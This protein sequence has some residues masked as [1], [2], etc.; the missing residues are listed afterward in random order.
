MYR[1]L[2]E[3][4]EGFTKNMRPAFEDK[5]G[6]FLLVGATQF[7]CFFAPFVAIFLCPRATRPLVLAEI[8]LIYA[9]R[10]LLTAR[11][12]TSWLGCLLHPIG[13]ALCLAIGLNS[14]RRSVGG[15][16]SWKGRTYR[17]A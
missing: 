17:P 2:G 13:H 8:A 6:G 14:W 3:T 15:G 16:V 7:V 5:L 1:S 4:W 12:R 9:I 10:I 11:F